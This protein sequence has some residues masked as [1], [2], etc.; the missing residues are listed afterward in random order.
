[1]RVMRELVRRVRV[2][3][4]IQAQT[5]CRPRMPIAGEATNL[6]VCELVRKAGS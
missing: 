1:M 6:R 2:D 5:C 3:A 4:K